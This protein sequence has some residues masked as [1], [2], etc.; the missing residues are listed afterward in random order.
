MKPPVFLRTALRFRAR[1]LMRSYMRY[2]EFF[3]HGDIALA[4]RSFPPMIVKRKRAMRIVH[5]LK[6]A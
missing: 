3:G 2:L 4:E 1:E 6:R 5:L